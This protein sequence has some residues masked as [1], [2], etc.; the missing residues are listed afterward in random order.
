RGTR[1]DVRLRRRCRLHGRRQ[2]RPRRARHALHAQ[3]AA[4]DRRRLAAA[5]RDDERA[6]RARRGRRRARRRLRCRR[7]R[8]GARARV[9]R[10]RPHAYRRGPGR[11]GRDRRRVQRESLLGPRRARLSRDALRPPHPRARRHARARPG[12]GAAP[13]RGRRVREESLRRARRR[14][15][16]RAARGRRVRPRRRCLRRRRGRGRRAP[17]A[18]R[19]R[20]DRARE[21]LAG[22]G[23]RADRRGAHGAERRRGRWIVL[24]HLTEHLTRYYSGFNV[25]N[26]LTM[27]AILSALTA[28]V[29]S[30]ALGPSLIQ[31]LSKQRIGQ[32]IREVGPVSHLP[33]AGTPTMGGALI[34]IAIAVSTLLW[35]DLRNRF[36]WIV[37]VVMLAFGLVGF[38]DD[39]K[40]LVLGNAEGL[41]PRAKLFWQSVAALGAAVTLYVTAENPDVEHALLIPYFKDL[42]IP[43]GCTAYVLFTYFV[44][45]GSSNA[46][47][48]TDGL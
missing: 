38:V 30:L 40:K 36:V 46:V 5:R 33:K 23:P 8:R 45:V 4:R 37:L 22:D 6:E 26:Y 13:R 47:N 32:Q 31:R 39:Y 11:R 17:V 43:L 34:L 9:R 28:L 14:R 3:D 29:L 20:R 16:A 10:S 24:M 44:I 2:A 18:P 25:F 12:R 19:R 35:A 15:P 1:A 48:L 21:G 7:G 42:M 27:R 41:R